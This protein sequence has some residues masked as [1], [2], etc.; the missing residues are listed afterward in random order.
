[1]ELPM[2]AFTKTG[3]RTATEK[4]S[5]AMALYATKESSKKTFHMDG[6]NPTIR[7]ADKNKESS[8]A[9]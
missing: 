4:L 8:S 2:R 9:E 1:M 7:T 5:T 6:G 3:K